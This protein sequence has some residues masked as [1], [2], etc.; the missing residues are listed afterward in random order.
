MTTDALLV[1][2]VTKLSVHYFPLVP[3]SIL[4]QGLHDITPPL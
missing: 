1:W 2:Q 4:S 3:E